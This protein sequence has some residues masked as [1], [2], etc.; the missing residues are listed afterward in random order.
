MFALFVKLDGKWV[1]QGTNN[2]FPYEYQLEAF[3]KTVRENAEL[4]KNA[5]VKTQGYK[6]VDLDADE[7]ES[8]EFDTKK[9]D[10]P[11]APQVAQKA[12]TIGMLLRF[13]SDLVVGR[14]YLIHHKSAAQRYVR[15]SIMTYLGL[16]DSGHLLWDARPA[17]GT[18]EMPTSWL[19]SVGEVDASV[20]H[21]INRIVNK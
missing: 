18:Q 4:S 8:W 10:S 3:R 20:P 1:S 6:I 12:E 11:E 17:A 2:G 15:Q 19:T 7:I 14:K 9:S 5:P 21:F 13:A 16:S